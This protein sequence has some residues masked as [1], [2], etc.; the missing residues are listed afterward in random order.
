MIMAIYNVAVDEEVLQAVAAE[1]VCC[2]TKF[3]RVV[4]KGKR[5]GPRLDN[6]I[7]PGANACTLMVVPD[8]LAPRVMAVLA[9]LRRDIGAA[10][11]I[12]AFLMNVEQQ[13]D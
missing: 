7:W 13:L 9:D 4:G 6:H 5:T 1:G 10:E 8:E 2:Y 12:K 3:P 11:G